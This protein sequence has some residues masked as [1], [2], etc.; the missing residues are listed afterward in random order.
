MWHDGGRP[1]Q[2]QLKEHHYV[3]VREHVRLVWI[4]IKTVL[5]LNVTSRSIRP[6]WLQWSST[7]QWCLCEAGTSWMLKVKELEPVSVFSSR[8]MTVRLF[9]R[10]IWTL[11]L[12]WVIIDSSR[13]KVKHCVSNSDT[14]AA[15]SLQCFDVLFIDHEL[16]HRS[17]AE[18]EEKTGYVCLW[19]RNNSS[20]LN[21]VVLQYM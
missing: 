16:Q 8:F 4:M 3:T 13:V 7:G 2:S 6:N 18:T 11:T 14:G 21:V 1:V 9:L 17:S 15:A 10:W 20:T 12:M 5:N 19:Y